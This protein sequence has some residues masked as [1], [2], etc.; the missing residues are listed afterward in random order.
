[1]F[2]IAVILGALMGWVFFWA[3]IGAYMAVTLAH[4]EDLDPVD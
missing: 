2:W 1:M 4:A 3:T